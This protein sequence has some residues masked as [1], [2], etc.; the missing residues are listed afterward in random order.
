MLKVRLRPE[1]KKPPKGA[2][3][4]AKVDMARMWNCMGEM[5][6][7]VGRAAGHQEAEEDGSVGK[8]MMGRE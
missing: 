4:E 7:E 5:V 2:M 8:G 3:R 6:R 1:A